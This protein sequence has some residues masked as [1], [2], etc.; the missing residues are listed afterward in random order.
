MS[1][2]GNI[3]ISVETKSQLAKLLATE[4]ITLQHNPG[5]QTAY[6]D[7][8]SRLL[9]LPVWQ[10]ISED[11][12]DMLVVHE[13]GHALDSDLEGWMGGI[14]KIAAKYH[15]KATNRNKSVIK[16]FLN[17][18]EDARIDKRQKRRYPGSRKNYVKAYKELH[19]RDFFKIK[20]EDVNGLTFIDRANI[21]FKGGVG[22]GIKFNTEEKKMIKRM[23]DAETLDEVVEIAGDAYYY[24][25]TTEKEALENKKVEALKGFEDE[26][27]GDWEESDEDCDEDGE[28][29]DGDSA[30]KASKVEKD[31][32][33]D[34]DASSGKDEGED[35]DDDGDSDDA[36]K[37][38]NQNG[39]CDEDYVPKVLTES[40]ARENASSIVSSANVDYFYVDL[41]KM[42][43]ENIVDDYKVVIPQMK[44]SVTP[45]TSLFQNQI[46]GLDKIAEELA[47]WKRAEQDSISFMVKEFEMKKAADAY[48][49]TSV[50]KTGVINTNKIH[51]Y[52]FNEDIFKKVA[53]VATGKNHGFVILLDWSGSMQSNLKDTIQQ[54]FSLVMFCKRVQIPF[55]V[56]T[57]R[58]LVEADIKKKGEH[59]NQVD[60]GGKPAKVKFAEFKLRNILSSRMSLNE[61]NDAMLHVYFAIYRTILSDQ[62]R[63]TP[64]AQA[65]LAFDYVI[66]KFQK[67]NK[68]QIVN[69]VIMT[70]GASD[71]FLFEDRK[72]YKREAH[73]IIR[74]PITKKSYHINGKDE[75]NLRQKIV[76]IMVEVLRSR[77][78][79]N[80]LGMYLTS[81]SVRYLSWELEQLFGGSVIMSEANVK[82]WKDN[83]FFSVAS[84]G[85]DEYYVINVTSTNNQQND[86]NVSKDMT[87]KAIAKEFMKYSNK[88]TV[89][90]VMLARFIDR[91]SKAIAK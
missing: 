65:I 35:G 50:A 75:K 33:E 30:N 64:L 27:E 55:E 13:V 39:N 37:S 8:K 72:G 74:D 48:A 84:A 3:A 54:L 40:A 66:N 87:S 51:S 49:R 42:L 41:P 46:G 18:V 79:C 9:V 4:N 70:D 47:T 56:Y 20:N 76:P 60:H 15:A 86:L 25:I 28:D 44:A 24:A 80:I 26:D 12:Y 83:R 21:Y 45:I 6:F 23:E 81:S 11:L 67:Q 5:V 22:F 89:N 61:L 63:S 78:N 19:E 36:T 57:F 62:F 2:S 82:S 38:P 69:A 68:V 52:K 43:H 34:G 91:I 14:D 85:Y 17:V 7:I 73:Y 77:T 71:P 32:D 59:L 90:R 29:E 88:K 31:G 10:N 1:T 53:T 58:N 16:D